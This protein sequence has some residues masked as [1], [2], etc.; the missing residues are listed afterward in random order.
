MTNNSVAIVATSGGLMLANPCTMTRR[1]GREADKPSPAGSHLNWRRRDRGRATRDNI[2][3]AGVC[4]TFLSGDPFGP[5]ADP[6][7]RSGGF[8]RVSVNG[9]NQ[10]SSSSRSGGSKPMRTANYASLTSM[11][12]SVAT[13]AG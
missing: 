3:L 6:Q 5:A 11:Q 8:D 4:A 2:R 13:R 10:C 7:R 1:P 12:R 9:A